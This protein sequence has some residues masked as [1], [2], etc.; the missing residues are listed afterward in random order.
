[1][2]LANDE[3]A[4]HVNRR[5]IH[6]DTDKPVFTVSELIEQCHLGLSFKQI[7]R[8]L[9]TDPHKGDVLQVGHVTVCVC[10]RRLG[11]LSACAYKS[12]R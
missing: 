5:G 10:Y 1:M 11:L 3:G 7:S 2:K 9:G 6:A 4:L 12:E 8:K